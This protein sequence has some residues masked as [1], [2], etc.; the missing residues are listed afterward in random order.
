MALLQAS[1]INTMQAAPLRLLKHAWV[2]PHHTTLWLD[3]QMQ[4]TFWALDHLT[5]II[6]FLCQVLGID[7]G[8]RAF[9]VKPL[10]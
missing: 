9:W 3:M 4:A 2:N 10:V 8:R 1:V 6:N 7:Y 5:A